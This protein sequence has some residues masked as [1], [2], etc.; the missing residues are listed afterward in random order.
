MRWS[1][2]R[3]ALLCAAALAAGCSRPPPPPAPTT[4]PLPQ[5]SDVESVLFLVGDPGLARTETHPILTRL[6]QDVEWW[7]SALGRDT[8]VAIIVLGD[9]I[10][11]T[12]MHAPGTG[13]FAGDSIT[14]TSQVRVVTGP[15]ASA[16]GSRLYFV[17][18]NH[19]WGLKEEFEGAVRLSHMADFLARERQRTGAFAYLVPEAGNGGPFVLDWGPSTRILFLDTAWW[20]LQADDA[21]RDRVLLGVEEAL[22]TAGDRKV[23]FAAH[24]PLRTAGSHGGEFS[25]W[26]TLGIQYI[27]S[28]TGAILQDL[29][30]IPYRRLERGLRFLFGQYGP[31]FAFIGGHE[32]NLQ[33][34]TKVDP[35]DPDHMIVSGSASKS[36]EVGRGEGLQFGTDRHGYM[37]LLLHRDGSVS[38]F[39]EAAPASPLVCGG[40]G[41]ARLECLAR[42]AASFET[43]YSRRLR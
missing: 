4:I 35:T 32:H 7:S 37:K 30:S 21:E 27:L 24:H 31:P 5:A 40:E 11:P 36:S 23:L 43:V 18:G 38:L 13:E 19:D 28:R 33:Y 15:A 9:M 6:Q 1:V 16:R 10:Y 41:E 14:M 39:V 42:G 29:N 22:R 34:F 8:S 2:A 17:P 26:S 3:L 20:L 25:F 12:G